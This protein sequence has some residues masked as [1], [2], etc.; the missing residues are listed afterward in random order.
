MGIVER[1]PKGGRIRVGDAERERAIKLLGEHFA[2]GRL[3]VHEYDE[4]CMNASAARFHAD[5][6]ALFEDLPDPRPA[7]NQSRPGNV[8]MKSGPGVAVGVG[9]LA[10]VLVL[11][12]L[13]KLPPVIMVLAVAGGCFVMLSRPR[14]G[15]K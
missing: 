11:A 5:L 15:A 3:D 14:G 2:A 7:S 8:P 13:L 9:V 1:S 10:V 12:V 6:L 4:R